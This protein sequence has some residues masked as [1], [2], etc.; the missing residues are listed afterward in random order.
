MNVEGVVVSR[1]STTV[2]SF[3]GARGRWIRINQDAFLS[4]SM[5]V[6]LHS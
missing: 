3:M 5:A 1:G 2:R 4:K 6:V